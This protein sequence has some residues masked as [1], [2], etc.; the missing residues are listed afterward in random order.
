MTRDNHDAR[1]ML[2]LRGMLLN[3]V[4]ESRSG[5]TS[6]PGDEKTRKHHVARSARRIRACVLA[7]FFVVQG[8]H[9][10]LAQEAQSDQPRLPTQQKSSSLPR[11]PAPH[12]AADSNQ[13]AWTLQGRRLPRH[14]RPIPLTAASTTCSASSRSSRGIQAK[15]AGRSPLRSATTRRLT[16]AYLNL[17]RMDMETGCDRSRRSF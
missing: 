16:G 10:F 12:P 13:E 6:L 1:R 15:R 11:H 14:S 7:G 2:S 8:A 9:P 3:S 17:S 4:V 5:V